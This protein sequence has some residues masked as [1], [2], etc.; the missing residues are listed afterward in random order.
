MEASEGN[1]DGQRNHLV[2]RNI[3]ITAEDL[4]PEKIRLPTYRYDPSHKSLN[5]NW[6]NPVWVQKIHTGT[7][8]LSIA[9][10]RQRPNRPWV[11]EPEYV[12]RRDRYSE[13]LA[14]LAICNESDWRIITEM[15]AR[16]PQE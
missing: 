12:S 5:I 11:G 9:I 16:R 13:M 14:D 10:V 15:H 3:T 1:S 2:S 8:A 4:R 6:L 7:E